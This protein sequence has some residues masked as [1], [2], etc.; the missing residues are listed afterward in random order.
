MVYRWRWCLTRMDRLCRSAFFLFPNLPAMLI[1]AKA[2]TTPNT[3]TS[4]TAGYVS[5]NTVNSLDKSTVKLEGGSVQYHARTWQWSICW[6]T[7]KN[8]KAPM[9]M[10]PASSCIPTDHFES[11]QHFKRF[12]LFGKFNTQLGNSNKLTLIA[13]TL[14]SNWDASGQIPER[15]VKSGSNWP[16]RLYW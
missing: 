6:A 10:W 15:A 4:G 2:P 8:K 14:N 5:M 1:M 12:N 11:A 16:V 7:A 3:A 13:S 9:R